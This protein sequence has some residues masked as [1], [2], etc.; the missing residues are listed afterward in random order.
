[1][2]ENQVEGAGKDI[3]EAIDNALR[4]ANQ[5]WATAGAMIGHKDIKALSVSSRS[6]YGKTAHGPKTVVV[7]TITI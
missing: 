4:R 1:M 6:T 2:T 3:D 5:V 7:A